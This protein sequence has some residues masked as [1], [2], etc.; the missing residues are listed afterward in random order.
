MQG[1]YIK[2]ESLEDYYL[3]VR[4]LNNGCNA[5]NIQ[6]NLVYA[7]VGNGMF[8]RRS[9]LKVCKKRNKITKTI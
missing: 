7:R 2:L 8:K 3:W 6:E 1:N 5:F 9:G 4:M